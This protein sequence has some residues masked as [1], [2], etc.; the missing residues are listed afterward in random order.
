MENV[1]LYMM[2][3]LKLT[4]IFNALLLGWD[5]K[6]FNSNKIILKKKINDMTNL[7]F[8]THKLIK[9]LINCD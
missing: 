2:L 5:V 6:C 8:N 1:K 9:I 3:I 4:A 7:D